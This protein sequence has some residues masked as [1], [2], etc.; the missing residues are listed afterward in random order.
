MTNTETSSPDTNLTD[1]KP[2]Q[3]SERGSSEPVGV[4]SLPDGAKHWQHALQQSREREKKLA[5]EA[6]EL[7]K[8]VEAVRTQEKLKKMS[9]MTEVERY[10]AIASEQEEKRAKL[11]LKLAVQDTLADKRIPR[12]VQDILLRTP[13][14]IP[15]VADELGDEFT[16]DDAIASVKRHLP[17]YVESLVV[18]EKPLREEAEPSSGRVD[19]ERSIDTG[20]VKQHIYTLEEIK[21]LGKDPVEWAKHEDAIKKQLAESGGRLPQ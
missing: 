5:E 20:V 7:R 10:K 2:V 6:E 14:A 17:A 1:G 21:R 15:A 19:S 13:W 18:D 9:E 8:Q 4:D 11:E 3:E 16:W 12:G